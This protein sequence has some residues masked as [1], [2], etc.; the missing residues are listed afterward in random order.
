MRFS[1]LIIVHIWLFGSNRIVGW[2]SPSLSIIW[3]RFPRTRRS[4]LK[5]AGERCDPS[6]DL[7]VFLAYPLD[8]LVDPACD[9]TGILQQARTQLGIKPLSKLVDND[10]VCMFLPQRFDCRHQQPA[11][12][13]R[14]T[15]VLQCRLPEHQFL[16]AD[17]IVPARAVRK[18]TPSAMWREMPRKH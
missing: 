7:L 13:Q 15:G 8:N 9:H 14:K 18:V 6:G 5:R 2:A 16:L 3:W 17:L 10:G 4:V 12:A 1:Q 11:L